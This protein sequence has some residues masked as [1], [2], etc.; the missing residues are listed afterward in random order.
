MVVAHAHAEFAGQ[1]FAM[2]AIGAVD[3]VRHEHVVAGFQE[4]EIDQRDGAHAGRQQQGMPAPF[5][6]GKLLAQ[7]L[8]G[9]RGVQ[10]V[11]PVGLRGVAI[12]AQF[13]QI[14]EDHGR[15]A[16]GRRGKRV[17]ARRD[18]E[19]GLDSQ[20]LEVAGGVGLGT[21]GH[22]EI[23]VCGRSDQTS[24]LTSK[25]RAG[26]E[27]TVTAPD[28]AQRELPIEIEDFGTGGA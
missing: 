13:V 5:D 19:F 9:G 24:E 10:A 20:R 28:L 17:E 2:V 8:A 4:R 18:V 12:G 6:L 14:A 15:A 3:V 27:A 22:G 11:A 23:L 21:V 1:P 26:R 7:R 16:I 25:C